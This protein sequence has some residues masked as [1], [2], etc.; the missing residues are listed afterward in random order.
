MHLA[1][2]VSVYDGLEHFEEPSARGLCHE[3]RTIT[4]LQ[5]AERS[6]CA[7]KAPLRTHTLPFPHAV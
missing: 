3:P 2:L 7:V 5:S 4:T 1:S 6:L